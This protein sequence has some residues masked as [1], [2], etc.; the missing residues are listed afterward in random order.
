MVGKTVVMS[1]TIVS[2]LG[3]YSATRRSQGPER[4]WT[5][6]NWSSRIY[7]E[8]AESGVLQELDISP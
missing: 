3:D 2:L 6:K 4:S 5:K 7:R 1:G 8:T